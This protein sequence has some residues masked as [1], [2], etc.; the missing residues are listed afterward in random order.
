MAE[1]LTHRFGK[2][3]LVQLNRPKA[4]N[5][6]NTSMIK[7]LFDAYKG[8]ERD[9]VNMIVLEGLGG[10]AFC[11]GGD[12]RAIYDG[13]GTHVGRDFFANEYR[14]NHLIGSLRIPHVAL[15][16]GI[17]MG[18]GVGVS[19]H[20]KYRVATE[21]TTFSMPET[22]IGLFPD[23]GGSFF[24]PRLG[25]ELGA[26]LGLTGHRLKGYEVVTAG[27]ATH[28]IHS[29]HLEKLKEALLH[30]GESAL[31]RH[32][33]TEDAS[34]SIVQL[35][36]DV[37]KTFCFSSVEEILLALDTHKS[38]W[39]RA[40][41]D[42]LMRMSP[43]SLKVTLRMLQNAPPTLRQ[44]LELEYQLG[45]HFLERDDFYEGVRSVLVDKDNKPVWKPALLKDV[46]TNFYFTPLSADQKQILKLD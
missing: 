45:N 4:L 20:G 30:E 22:A 29:D 33:V 46:D 27:I 14:L 25:R 15:I 37:E 28:Y 3:A 32:C 35:R 24:L 8:F 19:V 42:T 17:V 7:T 6:L 44:C 36:K 40:T 23:V 34:P 31:A 1:I 21:K 39:A 43:S 10:K 38:D 16:H 11:A 26:Y 9:G 18:G 41:K 12:V 5:A 13:R 2:T